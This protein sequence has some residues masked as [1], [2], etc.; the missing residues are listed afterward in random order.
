M[1]A[2]TDTLVAQQVPVG[3]RHELHVDEPVLVEVDP[4]TDQDLFR[5]IGESA[6]R[7]PLDQMPASDILEEP[8]AAPRPDQEIR[9]AIAVQILPRPEA[10]VAHS[11]QT[12]LQGALLELTI[13]RVAIEARR[14][15]LVHDQ[16]VEQPIRIQVTPSELDR[17]GTHRGL[18]GENKSEQRELH[19]GGSPGET[20]R[21]RAKVDTRGA[22]AQFK[23]HRRGQ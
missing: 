3:A 13:T 21:L 2:P 10:Q 15:L 20:G 19:H 22:W 12:H 6:L 5:Q 1:L 16:E 23:P 11:A 8:H 18:N 9:P 4:P 7:R 17:G 14:V